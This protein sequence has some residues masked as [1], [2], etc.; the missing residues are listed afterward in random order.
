MASY[1]TEKEINSSR[2]GGGDELTHLE[3]INEKGAELREFL[4]S[5]RPEDIP[6]FSQLVAR[7]AGKDSPQKRSKRIS[8]QRGHRRKRG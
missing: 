1:E 6:S 3:Q 8:H 2:V 7:G 5:V 4:A